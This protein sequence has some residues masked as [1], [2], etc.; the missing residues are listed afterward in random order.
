[1]APLL[2]STVPRLNLDEAK[3]NTILVPA[4]LNLTVYIEVA[5]AWAYYFAHIT[6]P[7]E[8]NF[9]IIGVDT[10]VVTNPVSEESPPTTILP[11][12]S[13]SIAVNWVA[14]VSPPINNGN[15]DWVDTVRVLRNITIRK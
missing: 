15:E 9:I 2:A 5:R 4:P 3:I 1:M 11:L 14:V 13:K 6:A 10:A 8:P 7:A 12:E